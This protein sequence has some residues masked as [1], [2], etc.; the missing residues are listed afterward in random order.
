MK[1]LCFDNRKKNILDNEINFTTFSPE[2]FL[3]FFW[4][5]CAICI[6]KSVWAKHLKPNNRS[7]SHLH[8]P[9]ATITLHA[10]I[11]CNKYLQGYQVEIKGGIIIILPKIPRC[12]AGSP[13]SLPPPLI[14]FLE[15]SI[16][17]HSCLHGPVVNGQRWATKFTDLPLLS[18]RILK[19]F[20][21]TLR[22]KIVI[23]LSPWN[24]YF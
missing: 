12:S 3:I 10:W 11:K 13:R 24:P 2:N 15:Y 6:F 18:K 16:L 9:V 5:K 22:H 21:N 19:T 7:I 8:I 14:N 20:E 1:V 23:D 17:M 4:W